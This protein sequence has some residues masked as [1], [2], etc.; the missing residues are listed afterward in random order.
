MT[1]YQG[2]VRYAGTSLVPAVA[3]AKEGFI[4]VE[5]EDFLGSTW[6]EEREAK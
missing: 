6:Y 4:I 3:T 1:L 2:K 5:V